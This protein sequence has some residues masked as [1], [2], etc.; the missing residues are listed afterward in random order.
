[1]ALIFNKGCS[2]A[3]PGYIKRDTAFLIRGPIDHDDIMVLY[4]STTGEASIGYP[5]FRHIR[6]EGICG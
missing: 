5:V 2:K 4:V 6:V 3:K 1:M